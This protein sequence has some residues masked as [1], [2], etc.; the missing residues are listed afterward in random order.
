MVVE[1]VGFHSNFGA[2]KRNN[3]ISLHSQY[4]NSVNQVLPRRGK[5]I[6]IAL[7]V[8]SLDSRLR[9]RETIWLRRQMH[10]YSSET[11]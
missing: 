7:L 11:V 4:I 6:S 8:Q 5:G 1:R 2:F 3:T 10:L 9:N